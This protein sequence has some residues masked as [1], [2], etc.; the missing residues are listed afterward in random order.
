M[1][2]VLCV[3]AALTLL[4]SLAL[5]EEQAPFAPMAE[6]STTDI[7]GNPVDQTVLEGASL[8]MVNVWGTFCPPCIG[9]MSDL[10]ELSAEWADMG[11][12]IIGLVC[13]VA[14]VEGEALVPDEAQ[15]IKAREIAE[16]TGAAYCHLVP[17]IPL[18]LRI[19]YGL[20]YVPTT[21]FVNSEGTVVG[22]VY[23][24]ANSKEKWN[25]IITQELAALTAD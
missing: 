16:E 4:C 2:K 9:E 12:R 5:A 7:Y 19:L 1:K 10:G 17:D 13:D 21:F 14:N 11:V 6:F 8:I 23:I 25:D 24:G 15:L 22:Q 20:Q 18:Y 3:L